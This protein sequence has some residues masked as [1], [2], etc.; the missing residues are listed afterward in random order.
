MFCKFLEIYY[1]KTK[2]EKYTNTQYYVIMK[3]EKL[4]KIT[5]SLKEQN[6]GKRFPTE[7]FPV[8]KE[9]I[10][11]TEDW[12]FKWQEQLDHKES[13]TFALYLKNYNEYQGLVTYE[14]KPKDKSVK[15]ILVE[16]APHNIG[17]DGKYKGVGSHLFAIAI[18]KS[19]ELGFD[20]Y[21]YFVSKTNLIDYYINV[22]GAKVVNYKNRT[23]A[24][25]G[26]SSKKLYET[27]ILGKEKI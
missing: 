6:T 26:V 16:R 24:I 1:N 7:F 8:T 2:R 10:K 5:S 12:N 19:Y 13:E 3:G 15:V 14:I 4:N 11:E 27:Y 23:M 22:L 20:G 9:N 21:V 17:K 18:K 25:A